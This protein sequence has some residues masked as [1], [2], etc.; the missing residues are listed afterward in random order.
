MRRI[1]DIMMLFLA[2]VLMAGCRPEE[3][4]DVPSTEVNLDIKV[5]LSDSSPFTRAGSKAAEGSEAANDN[6]KMQT[7]R[8]IIVRPDGKVEHNRLIPLSPSTIHGTERFSVKGNEKKDIYLFVNENLTSIKNPNPVDESIRRDIPGYDLN[9]IMEGRMFPKEIIGKL[10]I[11]MK[12]SSEELDGALPMNE[13]HS[14]EVGETDVYR[15]LFVT[16]AAVKFSFRITNRTGNTLTIDSLY[17][18]ELTRMAYYLPKN[19]KYG[20]NDDGTKEIIEYDV[21][22]NGNN[23]YYTFRKSSPKTIKDN[24]TVVLEPIYLLE[25]KYTDPKTGPAE[26]TSKLNYSISLKFKEFGTTGMEYFTNL[27]QLPRNTHV[28]T[29]ILV[30]GQSDAEWE[31]YIEPYR[32]IPLPL[33][34]EFGI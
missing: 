32:Y 8:I 13:M 34:P 9:T 29:D 27:G 1:A 19:A 17:I 24:E 14:V 20:I 12:S 3:L 7:L 18:N 30:K 5:S 25:G 23:D 10:T 22:N 4:A 6:E 31:V 28:V 33:E 11:E 15:E 2:A 16:R 26:G 21:P